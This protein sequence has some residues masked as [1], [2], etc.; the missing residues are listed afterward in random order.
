MAIVRVQVKRI[1]EVIDIY[2]SELPDG[3]TDEEV[4][5]FVE[6]AYSEGELCLV[7]A[8]DEDDVDEELLLDTIEWVKGADEQS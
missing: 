5:E 3:L 7:D 1:R 8:S 2:E 6:E 4:R